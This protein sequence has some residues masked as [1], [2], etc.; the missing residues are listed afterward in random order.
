M[1]AINL[2]KECHRELFE[3]L[4]YVFFDHLGSRLSTAVFS[5]P[6]ALGEQ[7]AM[8]LLQPRRLLA[9][10]EGEAPNELVTALKEAPHLIVI[11]RAIN[12]F[13][14]QKDRELA[15]PLAST[16][17]LRKSGYAAA[18]VTRM[19]NTMLQGIF[20]DQE[21]IFRDTLRRPFEV[22]GISELDDLM[23]AEELEVTSEWFIGEVWKYVGWDVL[24]EHI[25]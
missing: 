25:N 18:I 14:N 23:D 7:S 12:L 22:T 6:T 24:A 1:M 2:N 11:L 16:K 15:T 17:L 9:S 10:E 4:T 20:G 3:A 21:E 13:A 8:G 19:Q 5:E